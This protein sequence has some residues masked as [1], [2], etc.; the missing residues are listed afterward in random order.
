MHR[1]ASRNPVVAENVVKPAATPTV[2]APSS[3]P[4]PPIVQQPAIEPRAESFG[5]G[6]REQARKLADGHDFASAADKLRQ[7]IDIDDRNPSL[8][9]ELAGCYEKAGDTEK[10]TGQWQEIVKLGGTAGEYLAQAREKLKPAEPGPPMREGAVLG[11]MPITVEDQPDDNSARHLIVHVPVKARLDTQIDPTEV[12][13]RITCYDLV[14][15]KEVALTSATISSRWGRPLPTWHDGNVEELAVEYNLPKAEANSSN[16][17]YY[18]Y[19]ANVYYNKQ[20]QADAAD[21]ERLAEQFP[22]PKT[23]SP[24]PPPEPTKPPPPPVSPHATT[25]EIDLASKASP[26]V[27][28]LGMEFVPVHLMSGAKDDKPVLFC[29]WKTRLQD[30]DVFARETNR[31]LQKPPFAQENNHPAVMVDWSDAQAFLPSF[32]TAREIK[33]GKTVGQRTLSFT[34]GS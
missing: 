32:L 6:T 18:G 27:N 29:V 25:P 11:L 21:P 16:R 14:D 24:E 34:D 8:R 5:F 20:L 30:Y 22:A 4:P 7:A 23:F 33:A 15:G 2:S 12:L 10:A 9:A 1:P 17:T 31:S 19:T 28:T 26:F 13:V 3:T